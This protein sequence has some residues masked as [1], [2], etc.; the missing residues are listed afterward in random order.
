MNC[1][2]AREKMVDILYGEEND[3]T[4]QFLFFKHLKGCSECNDEYLELLGTREMLA[5]WNEPEEE[6]EPRRQ[7]A[8]PHARPVW[9]RQVHW[10]GLL[11][12]VAAGILIL[13]GIVSVM[14]QMGYL[15][16]RRAMVS[17]KELTE[18]VQDMIVANQQKERQLIGKML[19]MIKE[20]MQLQQ[21][22]NMQEVRDY[23]TAIERRYRDS[24]ETN[25]RYLKTLLTR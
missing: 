20:D 2:E 15:G 16:G 19:V 17:Q 24:Q 23:L 8:L 25:E 11:Q 9:K 18:M 1:E 4:S 10:W 13:V 12:R 21:D 3:M 22:A 5:E 14:Q 6:D 7:P